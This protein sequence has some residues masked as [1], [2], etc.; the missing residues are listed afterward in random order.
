MIKYEYLGFINISNHTLTPEQKQGLKAQY[1]DL[2]E[3]VF[4]ENLKEKW[5]N[6][7]PEN[8]KEVCTQI[9]EYISRFVKDLKWREKI[10]VHVAG[11]MPAVI[12]LLAR[13]NIADNVVYVYSYTERKSVEKVLKDGTIQKTAI[14]EHKGWFEYLN[15]GSTINSANHSGIQG[16]TYYY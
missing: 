14:F 4:P 10:I 5:G 8:Y 9:N 6:L 16:G 11:M 13:T 1:G 3:I 12:E 2:V 7:S 15:I